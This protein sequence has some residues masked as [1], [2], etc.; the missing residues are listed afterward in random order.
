MVESNKDKD[1][2]MITAYAA[3]EKTYEALLSMYRNH[4]EYK[5]SEILYQVFKLIHKATDDGASSV[6]VLKKEFPK[7]KLEDV[8]IFK[9]TLRMLGFD[10]SYTSSL[11]RGDGY[12]ISWNKSEEDG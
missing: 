11:L 8:W 12:K 6:W 1:T 10:I 2:G 7:H 5:S 3:S 9:K 4:P